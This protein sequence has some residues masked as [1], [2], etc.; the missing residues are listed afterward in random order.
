[1]SWHCHIFS[2][3]RNCFQLELTCHSCKPVHNPCIG[4]LAD[5]R[6]R[7]L[8]LSGH[9]MVLR[10]ANIISFWT[11]Q[12]TDLLSAPWPNIWPW[13]GLSCCIFAFLIQ[14]VACLEDYIQSLSLEWDPVASSILYWDVRWSPSGL[15]LRQITYNWVPGRSCIDSIWFLQTVSHYS[16]AKSATG[17]S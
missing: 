12:G 13:C 1:M 6:S 5:H 15:I 7:L 9:F 4:C 17:F 3:K 11:T 16:Y 10:C 2:T 8:D 14:L